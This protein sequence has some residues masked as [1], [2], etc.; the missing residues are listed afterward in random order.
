MTA[1]KSAISDAKKSTEVLVCLSLD[2]RKEVD[3]TVSKAVAG[4]ATTFTQPIDYGFMYSHSFQD[5]DGHIWELVHMDQ[6]QMQS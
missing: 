3:E 2:S 6:S 4:G 1:R 5:L